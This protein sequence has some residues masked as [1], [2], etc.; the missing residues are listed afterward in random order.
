MVSSN[1]LLHFNMKSMKPIQKY[2]HIIESYSLYCNASNKRLGR[3]L[4]FSVFR[5]G[6]YLRGRSKEGGIY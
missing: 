5:G 2:P 6:V 3:L 1:K 4:N